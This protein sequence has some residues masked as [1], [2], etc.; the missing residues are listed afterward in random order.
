MQICADVLV[1]YDLGGDD[2]ID[3]IRALRS[4]L[5]GFV[6]LE[7]GGGFG[8][9]VDIERSFGRLVGAVVALSPMVH[10]SL[11]PERRLLGL[12][13]TDPRRTLRT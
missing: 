3:A 8:L 6:S 12:T 2:A 5:H 13:G 1:A 7:A 4:M 11:A 10:R 9:P